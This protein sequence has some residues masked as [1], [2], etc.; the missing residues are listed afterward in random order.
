MTKRLTRDDDDY[1]EDEELIPNGND[2]LPYKRCARTKKC[3]RDS[4]V[5]A[6]SPNFISLQKRKSL[7]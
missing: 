7:R 3:R 5:V 1:F 2:S 4:G 6:R